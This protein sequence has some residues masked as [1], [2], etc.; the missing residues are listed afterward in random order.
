MSIDQFFFISVMYMVILSIGVADIISAL[1]VWL[2]HKGIIKLY[3]VHVVWVLFLL[4]VTF[5]LWWSI[6]EVQES[7]VSWNFFTNTFLLWGP[8][9]LYLAT[10][11]LLPELSEISKQG[12]SNYYF[13]VH[14]KFF[15]CLSL[16][17]VWSI[18]TDSFFLQFSILFLIVEL[19]TLALTLTLIF[20][21]NRKIHSAFSIII[22]VIF[23]VV[24]IWSGVTL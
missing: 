6:W 19:I 21:S 18:L 1:G 23:L 12:D 16:I 11:V 8:I 5:Q 2:K 20:S 22:W 10:K 17:L 9:L 4:A 15:S 3:W 14:R 13:S 7:K 24:E